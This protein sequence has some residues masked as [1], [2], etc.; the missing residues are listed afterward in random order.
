M[1]DITQS[2]F[3]SPKN[4]GST[5]IIWGA[6]PAFLIPTGTEEFLGPE[7]F[8]IGPTAVMLRQSDGW[9][10]GFLANHICSVQ[11]ER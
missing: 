8:G 6:G 2:L 11:K 1:G 4:P 5:G 7:K 10:Y 9:T 3:F